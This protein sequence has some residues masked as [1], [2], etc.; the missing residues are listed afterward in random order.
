MGTNHHS[1]E[2]ARLRA[3]ASANIDD[4]RLWR[5]YADLMEDGRIRSTRIGTV[6]RITIDD[7]CLVEDVSFD[8]AV[9]RAVEAWSGIAQAPVTLRRRKRRGRDSELALQAVAL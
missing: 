9:R 3:A 5:W 8:C 6:W 4:A 2:I 1:L 7:G